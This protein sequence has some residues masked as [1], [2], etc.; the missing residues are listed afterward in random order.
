MSNYILCCEYCCNICITDNYYDTLNNFT[1]YICQ[2]ILDCLHKKVDITVPGVYTYN[3]YIIKIKYLKI[4]NN[5]CDLCKNSDM[6]DMDMDEYKH[7]YITVIYPLLNIIK[8]RYIY[9]DGY[10]T[11]LDINN[12]VM[13]YF[14]LPKNIY[15]SKS[16]C[17]HGIEYKIISAK[18]KKKDDMIILAE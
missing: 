8:N 7:N 3:D 11:R 12:S 18:I 15:N 10:N 1:C 17:D 9:Y 13:K 6:M 5:K 14:D 16:N 2:N 4:Y